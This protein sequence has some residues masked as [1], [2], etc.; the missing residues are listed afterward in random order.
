MLLGFVWFWQQS[1]MPTNDFQKNS[2][3][4]QTL[5]ASIY[6][7]QGRCQNPRQQAAVSPADRQ[8]VAGQYS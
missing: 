5:R 4:P 8:Q 7:P 3:N 1:A 2:G 6:G